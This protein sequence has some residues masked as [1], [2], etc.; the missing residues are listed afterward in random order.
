MKLIR[1]RKTDLVLTK[2]KLEIMLK[3]LDKSSTDFKY[4]DEKLKDVEI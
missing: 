1:S 3:R 2:K 4:I